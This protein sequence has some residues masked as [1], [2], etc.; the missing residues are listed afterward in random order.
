MLNLTTYSY[1]VSAVKVFYFCTGCMGYI[2]SLKRGGLALIYPKLFRV[3]YKWTTRAVLSYEGPVITM[4]NPSKIPLTSNTK[5]PKQITISTPTAIAI[6]N[7]QPTAPLIPT[8][9]LEPYVAA[10]FHALSTI[11]T[12]LVMSFR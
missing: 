10:D 9:T 5:T 2:P 12:L 1:Y 11:I 3:E 6:S 7:T 8:T 4:I